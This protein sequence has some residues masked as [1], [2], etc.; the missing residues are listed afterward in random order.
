MK[1]L[2]LPEV[3][4]LTGMSR[5]TIYVW[6]NKG[7]FPVSISLGARSVGWIEHEVEEWIQSKIKKSRES[8]TQCR[9]DS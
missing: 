8:I 9:G 7:E 1:I 6:M 4:A 5:S 3:I 2:R